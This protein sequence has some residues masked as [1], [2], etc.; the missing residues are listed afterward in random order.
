M[1]CQGQTKPVQGSQPLYPGVDI[2]KNIL[3]SMKNPVHLL[4]ITLLTQLRIDG[5]PSIYSGRGASY[6]DCSHWCLAG[7]P[8][9]WNEFLYA[10]LIGR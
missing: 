6:V 5:H 7:V 9:T 2:V 3:R 10:A 8:D 4:D 1:G